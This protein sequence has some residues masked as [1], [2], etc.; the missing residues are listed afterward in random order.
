LA[1]RE[2]GAGRAGQRSAAALIAALVGAAAW[3][4]LTHLGSI[5][6]VSG[7]EGWWGV[8]ALAWLEGRPYIAHTTSGNPTDLFLL[9]PLAAVHAL[10]PPSFWLLRLVPAAVNL[11]ALPVGFWF[12]RRIYGATTAW[13]YTVA[14][15][16][17]PTAMAHSRICQDPSQS[18]FWTGLVIYLCLLAFAERDR[19]W[20]FGCLALAIFPIALWT[21]PTN[22]FAAPFLLLPLAAVL[23]PSRGVAL[24]VF[25]VIVFAV[26]P[27]AAWPALVRFIQ[28][29]ESLNRPWLAMA[30]ARL[31]DPAQWLEYAVNC[32][33]L[34][35]GVTIYH[36]F[37]GA[38]PATAPYDAG[39]LAVAGAA[40][41]GLWRTRTDG[42]FALDRAAIAA[43]ALMWLLFFAFAGPKSLRPHA[44]RWG[45]CLIVPGLLILARGIA[46]WIE[47]SPRHRRVTIAV[48]SVVA[49]LVLAGFYVN[50]VRA[51]LVTGGRGHLT[52]VTAPVEPKQAAL[53]RILA[54][55]HDSEPAAIVAQTWWIFW[56]T[57][58]L[59]PRQAGV[60]VSQSLS[61][62]IQPPL[63]DALAS[64]RL[65][66]VEFTGSPELAA[67]RQ[68]ID[69]RGLR[70]TPSTV[71][72][73]SGRDLLTILQVA[74]AR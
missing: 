54:L 45:L 27:L 38:R 35:N 20:L 25:A 4:R 37:S 68:W 3:L 44:E 31:V 52:Y 65:F 21:H 48:S 51:F 30:L 59:A 8:N 7:D 2:S 32:V 43:A 62:D 10:G 70:A 23:A 17:A 5:P 26:L 11:L 64:G 55:R 14:L 74:P 60:S 47:T 19:A 36:Y 42:R 40:I 50:F 73:A 33:R 16:I 1:Q 49:V 69:A 56:P 6:G 57:N 34:F 67:A 15:A 63:R 24:L 41:A 71:Q 22:V 66:I 9:V 58:Y 12:V 53:E 13:I 29:N 39:F 72:D 46:A 28:S 18:I 61:A